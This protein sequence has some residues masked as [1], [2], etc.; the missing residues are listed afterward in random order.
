MLPMAV[1]VWDDGYGISVPSKYQITKENISEIL[2]G[3]EY[4]E[5]SKQGYLIYTAKGAGIIQSLSEFMKRG[6]RQSGKDI[7]PRSF[8]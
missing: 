8:I 7:F 6:L 5:E 2:K 4:D 1:S 3:F